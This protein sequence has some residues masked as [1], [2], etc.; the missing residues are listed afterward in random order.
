M[1]YHFEGEQ[2][3]DGAGPGNGRARPKSKAINE[4]HKRAGRCLWLSPKPHFRILV[5]Q[6]VL[7]KQ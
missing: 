5:Q 3:N 7:K 2:V 1:I 6:S 4:G